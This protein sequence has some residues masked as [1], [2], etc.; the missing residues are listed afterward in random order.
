MLPLWRDA[1]SLI[2]NIAPGLLEYLKSI[3]LDA[4]PDSLLAYIGG[5]AAHPGFTER[6]GL[7]LTT[8]GVRIPITTDAALWSE[9][10]AAGRRV[11]WLQTY[12]E[13][14]VKPVDGRPKGAPRLPKE[15]RPVI[16]VAIP[17]TEDG[18]PD[19]ASHDSSSD[20]LSV[21]QGRISHVPSAVWNYEVSTY[22]V[23]QRWIKRRLRVPEGK[24]SSDL[25]DVVPT[26]W[27]PDMTTE[28]L[29]VLNVVGLLVEME[30][31]QQDLLDRVIETPTVTA[32]DLVEA[33]VLP[34]ATSARQAVRRDDTPTLF[35]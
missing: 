1:S 20:V 35:K 9:V 30:P 18:M 11:I 22:R 19:V 2:A 16:E 21:G 6:F 14:F 28:L 7:E 27:T 15:L 25:D 33:G 3:G 12:G 31:A 10:V 24:R 5:I 13:R 34:V 26:R 23:V 8:P 32:T 17:D 4:R 29:D